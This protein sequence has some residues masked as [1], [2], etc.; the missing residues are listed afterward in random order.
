MEFSLLL[1]HHKPCENTG[2]CIQE[3][4]MV[5]LRTTTKFHHILSPKAARKKTGKEELII[6]V[7]QKQTNKN[8]E[9]I[10]ETIRTK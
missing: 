6:V 9:Q 7:R 5:K 4:L 8:L 1:G 3:L 2:N 10:K